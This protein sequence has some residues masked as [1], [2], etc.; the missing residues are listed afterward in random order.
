M[1]TQAHLTTC[2]D[3]QLP[4]DKQLI[5]TATNF[6]IP[7]HPRMQAI[8]HLYE[9]YADNIWRFA[10]SRIQGYGD[11]ILMETMRVMVEKLKSGAFV[12]SGKPFEAWLIRIAKNLILEHKRKHKEEQESL[13]SLFHETQIANE[14]VTLEAKQKT[15]V[16][17][18][19]AGLTRLQADSVYHRHVL[20]RKSPDIAADLNTTSATVRHACCVGLRK[21]RNY[22]NKDQP[23]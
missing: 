21:L 11:D 2:T 9:R 7:L 16:M 4:T 18:D 12:Y 14:N 19:E 17:M 23:D 1:N 15:Y 5:E 22:Y 20:G 10:E 8:S 13:P 6:E 3:A